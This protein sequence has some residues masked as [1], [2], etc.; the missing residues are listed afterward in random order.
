VALQLRDLAGLRRKLRRL[1]LAPLSAADDETAND[2]GQVGKIKVTRR[3]SP[4][5]AGC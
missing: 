1:P 5:E 3:D 4:S 2:H